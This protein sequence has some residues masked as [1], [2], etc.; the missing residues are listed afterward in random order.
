MKEELKMTY[1]EMR[2]ML[3]EGSCRVTFTKVNGEERVMN[4]TLDIDN[5]PTESLPK[6]TGVVLKEESGVI[7][8]FDTDKSA[9]RSFKV[10]SV[11]DFVALVE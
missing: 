3:H 8:A 10:E 1:N 6:G 4:C 5:I 11:T 2:E 9:W 7:R